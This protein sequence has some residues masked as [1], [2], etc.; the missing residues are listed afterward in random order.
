M[1]CGYC[2]VVVDTMTK[3][4]EKGCPADKA[5]D[6]ITQRDREPDPDAPVA[7][8]QNRA[9]RKPSR[10]PRSSPSGPPAADDIDDELGI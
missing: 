5:Y 9:G 6:N 4:Y 10:K 8:E 3:H 7:K 1:R 2:D